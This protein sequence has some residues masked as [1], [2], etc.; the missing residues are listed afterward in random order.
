V[1]Q[2]EQVVQVHLAQLQLLEV[3]MEAVAAGDKLVDIIIKLETQ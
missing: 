2:V 3:H 1:A